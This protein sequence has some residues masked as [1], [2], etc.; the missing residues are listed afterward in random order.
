MISELH[1]RKRKRKK[2]YVVVLLRRPLN[3][4]LEQ[5]RNGRNQF[6]DLPCVPRYTALGTCTTY[7]IVGLPCLQCYYA[8]R[9]HHLQYVSI[10]CSC[11]Y[12][13]ILVSTLVQ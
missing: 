13:I 12:G 1:P 2:V 10:S 7:R 6:V 8:L 3:R 11:Y 9:M 5:R 4:I